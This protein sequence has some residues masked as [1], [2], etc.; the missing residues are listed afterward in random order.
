MSRTFSPSTGKPYGVVRVVSVWKLAR[1]SFYAARQREQHPRDP[2]K[3]G[4]KVLS[5]EEIGG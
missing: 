4:P 5:D 2:Q 3:R 1:A